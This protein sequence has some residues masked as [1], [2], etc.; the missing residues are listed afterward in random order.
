M[1]I[2]LSGRQAKD[3]GHGLKVGLGIFLLNRDRRG[4]TASLTLILG[5]RITDPTLLERENG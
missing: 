5:L 2:V 3:S 1:V 4:E